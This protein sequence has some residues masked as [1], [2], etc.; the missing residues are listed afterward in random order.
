MRTIVRSLAA[1]ALAAGLMATPGAAHA[2]HCETDIYVFSYAQTTVDDPTGE[3]RSV[4]NPTV[5]SNAIGCADPDA[6]AD[7]NWIYPGSNT[8]SVRYL[9]DEGGDFPTLSGTVS[10]L[11]V[12]KVITLTRGRGTIGELLGG[13][14]LY[15]SE[16]VA[17]DPSAS[18]ELVVTVERPIG[19]DE[20]GGFL[21]ETI[22]ETYRT[23]DQDL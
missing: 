7:T 19:V 17:I 13:R 18:G 2:D 14:F 15:D 8:I 12:D 9:L 16:L 20:N 22:S 11:G 1:V 21:W 6:H 4:R 5:T 10:G 23:V 3:P